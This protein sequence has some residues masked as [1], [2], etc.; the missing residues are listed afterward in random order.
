MHLIC[1]HGTSSMPYEMNDFLPCSIAVYIHEAV[2]FGGE[3]I[4]DSGVRQTWI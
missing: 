2:W 3:K 4:T 1:F